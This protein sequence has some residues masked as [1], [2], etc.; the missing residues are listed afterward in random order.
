MN[1]TFYSMEKLRRQLEEQGLLSLRDRMGQMDY[2]VSDSIENFGGMG[3]AILGE[4]ILQRVK[5]IDIE[6]Y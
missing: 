6:R 4:P 1:I 2:Y 5:K 3:E